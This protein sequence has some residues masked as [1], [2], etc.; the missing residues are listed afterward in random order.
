MPELP[1]IRER[2]IVCESRLFLIE[3]LSLVFG[4][5]ATREYERLCQRHKGA[6]LIVPMLDDSTVL[7]IREYAAGIHSYTLGMPK[8][9]I[10][11]DESVI[12]AANREL[13]EEIHYGA[14]QLDPLRCIATSAGYLQSEIQ[15]VL[16]RDLY[17]ASL[18]GDEPEPL[19][20]LPWSINDIDSLLA[21]REFREARDIAALYLAKSFLKT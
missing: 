8:G 20:V 14:K 2:H 3:R 16:A 17:P 19:E 5:G 10:A 18:P 9:A 6:V 15:V 12:D 7:L 21:H 13:Q 11:Q 4:N 1:H